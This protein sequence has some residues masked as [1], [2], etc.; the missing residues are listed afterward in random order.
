MDSGS[1]L[2]SL[3][4]Y[5]GRSSTGVIQ[6]GTLSSTGRSWNAAKA[7]GLFWGI[8]AGTALVPIAHFVLVPTFLIAGPI[9]AIVAYARERIV[10]GGSASCPNCAAAL[11]PRRGSAPAGFTQTCA[12]CRIQVNVVPTDP[13]PT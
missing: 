13:P 1:I 6:V 10:I 9:A 2:V 11:A 12:A 4:T 7:L 8:A 5:N 3:T